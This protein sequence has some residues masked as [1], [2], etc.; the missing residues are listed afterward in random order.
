MNIATK[1]LK[2][3]EEGLKK[4]QGA[5]YRGILKTVILDIPDAYN[6][7]EFALRGH[8]GASIIGDKC[9][10]KL[11]YGFRWVIG[12]SKH[13]GRL[14]RLFNRGHLEEPR[15]IALLLMIGVK[16]SQVDENGK[17]FR[18]KHAWDHFG[19]SS[20]GIGYGI[21]DLPNEYVLLE[22]KTANDKKFKE[23][24][25]KGVFEWNQTYYIQ[26]QIYMYKMGLKRTLFMCVNKNNDELH[27]EIIELDV[28]VAEINLAKSQRIIST[29]E[30]PDKLRPSVNWFEC[31]FC[32]YNKVCH[33]NE[34]YE[35]TCRT[36]KNAVICTGG[37]W[38]CNLHK[39]NLN[40]K[41]QFEACDQ[42]KVINE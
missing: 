27:A 14:L 35:K 25:S 10:R 1:T 3:L 30:P 40:L 31:K 4:D 5:K 17:Q 12:K 23:L 15:F 16:I 22:F 32:D 28:N 37:I 29:I 26:C 34:S 9:S 19:G 24:I 38:F 7:S 2:A 42:Y 36:C 8:L 11:W 33:N 21:P 18:I 41:E 39:K 6:D 20:D 13:S